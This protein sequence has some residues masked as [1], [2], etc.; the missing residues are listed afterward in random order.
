[1]SDAEARAAHAQRLINDP[2]LKGAFKDVREA[3]IDIWAKTKAGA[4]QEREVAWLTVKVLDRI[5]AEL[6]NIV[7]NGKIAAARVQN[8]VN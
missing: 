5:E 1:M 6:E 7:T 3:A 4:T 8:P 2:M